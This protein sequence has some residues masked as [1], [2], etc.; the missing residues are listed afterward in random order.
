MRRRTFLASATAA[1]L[2]ALAG[3]STASAE[4]PPPELP[5]E[6]LDEQGYELIDQEQET[7][8][9]E[10]L[11]G[12]TLTA[13][14]HTVVY[15]DVPLTE[16]V[17]ERTL[18]IVEGPLT[19]FFATRVGFSPALDDLPG[20]IGRS[21]I[22][23]LVEENAVESF[24]QQLASYGVEDVTEVTE[25][26]MVTDSGIDAD[27]TEFEGV[28]PFDGV[29]F[30]VTQDRT[31]EIEADDVSVQ[32][33]LAVWFD[34]GDTLVAGGV[35]PGETFEESVSESLSSGIDVSIEIDMGLEPDLYREE[36]HS[37]MNAVR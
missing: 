3:C 13:S 18:G 29:E 21:Q 28:V 19:T 11:A 31:V 4:V 1:G 37:F 20:G 35:H 12:M 32:G 10:S 17:T 24:R 25:E 34:D 14:A 26:V 2:A 33:W 30:P 7:V 22:L 16:D 9:E 27:R 23:D 8:F 15:E 6:R 5:T 36:I